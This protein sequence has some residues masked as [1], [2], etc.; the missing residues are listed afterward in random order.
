MKLGAMFVLALSIS[1]WGQTATGTAKTMGACSP[2]TSGSNNQFIIHCDV[3]TVQGKEMVGILNKIL[4]NQLATDTV[5]AKLEEMAKAKSAQT[6]V[7]EGPVFQTG[8]DCTQNVVG[9]NNNTNNCVPKRREMSDAQ[10]DA[11]AEQLRGVPGGLAIVPAGASDDIEP[12]VEKLVRA[13][14]KA[15]WGF[16]F[17]S[18]VEIGGETP[19][20]DGIQCYSMDWNSEDASHFLAAVKAAGLE[21]TERFTGVYSFKGLQYN[22][23]EA[24][25]IGRPIIKR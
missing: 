5:M 7:V 17:A 23:T 22:T 9:G 12:L 16:S 3:N 10:V 15:K 11:F 13:V 21:C 25:V 1:C 24:I 19:T 6:T 20:A 4:A 14:K 8:G 18:G 2:A